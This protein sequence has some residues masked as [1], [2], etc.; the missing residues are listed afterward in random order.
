MGNAFSPNLISQA[1]PVKRS[2]HFVMGNQ[3]FKSL[4][5]PTYLAMRKDTPVT[6][7]FKNF[8]FGTDFETGFSR[9]TM[10]RKAKT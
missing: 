5:G 1:E 8:L 3:E 7:A 9:H 2:T 6:R 10:L 4:N